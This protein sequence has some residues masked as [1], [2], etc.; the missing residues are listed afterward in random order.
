MFGL[1]CGRCDGARNSPAYVTAYEIAVKHGYTGTEKEWINTMQSVYVARVTAKTPATWTCNVSL[2][3]LLAQS[4]LREIH[5]VTL[6]GRTAFSSKIADDKIVFR[7]LTYEVS[8]GKYYD[9]YTLTATGGTYTTLD[10]EDIDAGAITRTMLANDVQT[11]LALADSSLQAHQSLAGLVP[12]S[13]QIAKTFA[14]TQRVAIDPD[15][16]LWAKEHLFLV[17]LTYSNTNTD[18]SSTDILDAYNAGYVVVLRDSIGIEYLL[19]SVN[20]TKASFSRAI[21]TTDSISV[22][23]YT[24]TGVVVSHTSTKVKKEPHL[25]ITVSYDGDYFWASMTSTQIENALEASNRER[26]AVLILS[27]GAQCSMCQY[28]TGNPKV[29][30]FSNVDSSNITIYSVAEDGKVTYTTVP[31]GS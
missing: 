4:E 21:D 30:K 3:T 6:E 12:R 22:D 7:T 26:H 27:D 14:H 13:Q 8:G 28:P 29:A 10:V 9:E 24:I 17:T 16:K 19:E 11:S 18:K 5:L 31:I 25:F 1:K 2:A 20:S 23:T 15:G